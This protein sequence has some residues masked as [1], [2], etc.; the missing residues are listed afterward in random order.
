MSA[1]ELKNLTLQFGGLVVTNDVSLTLEKGAR[2]ALI[3][4]NGAGKTTLI[5]L[6]TG[7]L[8]PRKGSVLLD[9][10]DLKGMP[11]HRRTR[12]GL[13]RNFQVTNLFTTFTAMEN[14]ALAISEREGCGL[15]MARHNGFPATV[16]KE[17]EDI[18]R[19]MRLTNVPHIPV[20]DLAYGQQRLV[21]LG[22]AMALRP[23][24]LLLD[25]PAAGLP[26]SDHEVILGVLDELPGDVAVLLVEH[27]MPLV[28]RFARQITVLAEGTVI[29]RGTPEE[30]R[31]DPQVRTAYLGNRS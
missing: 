30:I 13:V 6:I 11:Q 10:A 22:V 23:K 4:P 18:A 27:D 24:V 31:H 14:I 2:H 19:R 20:R 1:L 8:A 3:G 5:N 25:E 28:F 15:S 9:G 21:E 16:V 7:R 17:A 12:L 29:A 26:A